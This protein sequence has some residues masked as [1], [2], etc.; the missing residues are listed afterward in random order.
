MDT[1]N[2]LFYG[3]TIALQPTNLFYCFMGA[4]MGTLVGVTGDIFTL[5]THFIK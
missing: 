1:L 3:F 5:L 4:L 2:S